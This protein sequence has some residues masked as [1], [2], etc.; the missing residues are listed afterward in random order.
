MFNYERLFLGGHIALAKRG[1][2]IWY[3]QTEY[4]NK[5]VNFSVI[6]RE[7]GEHNNRRKR[8]AVYRC[9]GLNQPGAEHGGI[10]MKSNSVIGEK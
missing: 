9:A 2:F 8:M 3:L 1:Q 6:Y 10:S 7:R 5:I 4:R